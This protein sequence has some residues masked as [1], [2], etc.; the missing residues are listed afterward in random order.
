VLREGLGGWGIVVVLFERGGMGVVGM[1]MDYMARRG[2][3]GY[4]T[5]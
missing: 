3:M 2:E 4:C 1:A 5:S